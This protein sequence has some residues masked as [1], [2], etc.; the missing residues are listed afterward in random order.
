MLE[1]VI[2]DMDG[3]IFD[4]E[5]IWK[6]KFFETNKV[7]GFD[8]SEEY[9][10]K[11]MAGKPGSDVRKAMKKEFPNAKIDE[12]RD[13]MSDLVEKE[14]KNRNDLL[15]PGFLELV[16][17]L[18]ENK[19]KIA[20]ATSSKMDRC[21]LLFGNA[22]LKMEN[23]FDVVITKDDIVKGK[24]D[25]EI[26]IKAI[27]DLGSKPQDTIVFED[28]LLGLEAAYK[29]GADPVMVVDLI[30]PNDYTQKICK[31]VVYSL[32]EAKNYILSL[33]LEK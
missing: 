29:S 33:I 15:K 11:N 22:G 20:L 21:E 9:R 24:P 23:I 5:S 17:C 2:F 25:P 13:Y 18:K 28:S 3:V 19:I 1:A 10:Q 30:K 16:K 7:F 8:L 6:E 12:Y 4:T 27:A 26:F 31:N 32:K 14:I